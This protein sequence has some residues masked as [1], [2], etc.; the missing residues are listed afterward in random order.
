MAAALA[1][2][3]ALVLYP[4]AWLLLLPFRLIGIGVEGVFE[5]L[6]AIVMLP[7]RVLGGG[8]H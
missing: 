5:L 8:R 6:R 3:L 1:R 4:L 2:V 7:A